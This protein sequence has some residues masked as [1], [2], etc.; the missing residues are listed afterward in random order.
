M[1]SRTSSGS[2]EITLHDE[3]GS[4]DRIQAWQFQDG[5]VAIRA[6]EQND[7]AIVYLSPSSADAL[8]TWL[9]NLTWRE[10]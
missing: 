4:S 5:T 6:T 1:S 9:A 7:T 2:P 10:P 8:K 3:D